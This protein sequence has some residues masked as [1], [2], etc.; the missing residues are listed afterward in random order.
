MIL[1]GAP[2][3]KTS[4]TA[5][6]RG[7]RIRERPTPRHRG[8]AFMI[9][10]DWKVT[11]AGHHEAQRRRSHVHAAGSRDVTLHIQSVCQCLGCPCFFSIDDHDDWHVRGLRPE[12][13]DL[14]H[15]PRLGVL[16]SIHADQHC[17]RPSERGR[18]ERCLSVGDRQGREFGAQ[19][20]EPAGE[21]TPNEVAPLD[22][23]QEAGRQGHLACRFTLS[24]PVGS[25]VAL[26][27]HSAVPSAGHRYH[28]MLSFI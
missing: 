17:R 7:V 10:Q 21:A 2:L 22:D 11:T 26:F 4:K 24:D 6:S 12:P 18:V 28:V 1:F 27:L 19:I 16:R 14:T 20:A 8:V 23:N 13:S 15:Q 9:P 25:S 3:P 5:A